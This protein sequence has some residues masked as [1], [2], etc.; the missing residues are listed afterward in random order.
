MT[1]AQ[2]A[3]RL[4]IKA[5]TLYAYVSRGLLTSHPVPGSRQTRF[6]ESEVE[7]VSARGRRRARG[8]GPELV[9]DSGLTLLEPE[10]RLFYRGWDA[11][12]A[13]SKASYEQVAEW[14]WTASREEPPV[15][16]PASEHL[17]AARAAQALLPASTSLVDRIRV[18]VAVSGSLDPY[19]ADRRPE[20]VVA[21][22]RSLIS[23]LV[24][25][26]PRQSAVSRSPLDAA[27]GGRR[28]PI[29]ARLW[30]KL[31]GRW[32]TPETLRMLNAALVLLADHELAASTLAA[33]IAASTWA[34]PYLVVQTG[35]GPVGGPLHGAA[36]TAARAVIAEVDGGAP[37]DQVLGRLVATAE[38]LVPGLG[39]RVYVGPDPRA[40]TLLSMT[41]ELAHPRQWARLQEL[42]DAA[43][44][45]QLPG[46][47]VDFA[48]AAFA[49]MTELVPDATD[50]IFA[51]ARSAGWIAHAMEEYPH[52]LRFRIR[53]AYTGPRPGR[54]SRRSTLPLDERGTDST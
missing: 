10:G 38:G 11:I 40:T 28:Q 52:R 46:P 47:N 33:R 25:A 3:A 29:A 12:E 43:S 1:S 2:A 14:L 13:A 49:H 51:V 35:L 6:D 48:M 17:A 41:R 23:V 42:L 20:A 34:G 27:L 16:V 7:R 9:V 18:S 37:A 4:G 50:A 53:A 8:P 31:S 39:H 36:A 32:P 19:A 21:T 15:W 54:S 5:E 30:S 26:L 22:A 45:R 44:A 24:D